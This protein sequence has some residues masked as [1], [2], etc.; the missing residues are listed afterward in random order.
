MNKKFLILFSLI[1]NIIHNVYGESQDQSYKRMVLNSLNQA[2]NEFN[3][4]LKTKTYDPY[5][6]ISLMLNLAF[7]NGKIYRGK[8]DSI[9]SEMKTFFNTYPKNMLTLNDLEKYL[10]EKSSI[11]NNFVQ[12]K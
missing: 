6:L 10:F 3:T 7:I 4:I 8:L 11:K 2:K 9:I 1:T 12:K 5:T